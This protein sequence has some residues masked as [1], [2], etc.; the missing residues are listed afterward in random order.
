MRPGR[1]VAATSVN[2]G[3][4]SRIDRAVGPLPSTTSRLKSSRA[5]YRTSSTGRGMRWISSTNST[6]PSSRLVRI[7]ARSLGRSS[8]GPDVGWNPA[9]IS[10]GDDLGE[11]GLAEARRSA[12]Q[13][14]VDRLAPSPGAVDQQREL[15]LDPLLAHELRSVF[16]RSATSNS[17]SSG[18]ITAASIRRSSSIPLPS[19]L[20]QGLAQQVLHVAAVALDAGERLA[21]LG[22]RQTQ[23][24]QRL[25]HVG[26]GAVDH[27]LALAAQLVA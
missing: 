5:G 26:E 8:A 10:I 2:R 9:P 14:V 19:H 7:A 21:G 15:L 12:E 11:R 23:R 24:Q 17:R 1:V 13:Q 3:S 16:G 22:R 27:D 6:S 25:A 20:L 18:S 4:S